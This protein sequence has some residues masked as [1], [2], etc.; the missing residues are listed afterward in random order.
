MAQV[1]PLMELMSVVEAEDGASWILAADETLAVLAEYNADGRKLILSTETAVVP[2]KRRAETYEMIL[3]FN[4]QWRETG[5]VRMVLE[6]PGEPIVQVVDIPTEDLDLVDLQTVLGNVIAKALAWRTIIMEG[7]GVE[8]GEK[9]DGDDEPH[10]G[11]G[12]VRV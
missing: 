7:T 4:A 11:P 3:L 5:G 12:A 1:G 6:A 9:V 10:S 8:G 2:E